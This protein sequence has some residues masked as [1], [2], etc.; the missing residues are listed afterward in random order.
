MPLFDERKKSA[1]R[2]FEHDRE[3]TFKI[4]ARRNKLLGLWAAA[5]LGLTGEKAER[6]AREIVETEVTGPG[7]AAVIA[8]ICADFA[9]SGFPMTEQEVRRR[10]DVF[11]VEARNAVMRGTE[12]QR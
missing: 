8:R 4:A 1:E 2:K 3:L 12:E 6:Y 11:R 5:H 7:E 9:A 10:L